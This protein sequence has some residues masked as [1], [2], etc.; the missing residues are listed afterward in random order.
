MGLNYKKRDH[1]SQDAMWTSYS[2]LFLGLSIIFLLLYVAASLRQG[3]DGIRQFIENKQLVQKNADLQQ[4]IKVYNTLKQDYLKTQASEEEQASYN[5]LME[6]LDLLKE[7][8][9]D[10]KN[11]LRQKAMDNEKKEVALN[12]YQQMIRNIINSNMIAKSRIKNRDTLIDERDEEI[13]V[14]ESEIQDL[15]KNVAE[16]RAQI[17]LG[18]KKIDT[19]E[20]Q[21]D[22]KLKQLQSSY[23]AQKL[24]KK[25]YEQQQAALRGEFEQKIDSLKQQN[26]SASQE[27]SK[28]AQKLQ[29]TSS[30]LQSTQGQLS[31]AA[32]EK[33]RLAQDKERLAQDLES[34]KA[35]SER[36]AKDL[37]GQL[38]T[39]GKKFQATQADLAK[40]TDRL[41]AQRNLAD[42]IKKSFG[43][44]GVEADVDAETGDVI[45]SFGDQY[46]DTGKANLKPQ[47]RKILEQAMPVYSQSLFADAKIADKIQSVE[48]VGFAS[49]TFKGKFIDPKSLKPEDRQ[50]IN[51]NLD[52]SYNRARSIFNHVFDKDKM[53]FDHQE[54][55]IPLVKVTGRSFLAH[56]KDKNYKSSSKGEDFCR[57]NDCAKLQRVIIK[58]TLKD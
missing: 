11:M 27:L 42:K 24:T 51:Y 31:K 17:Q 20:D 5:V 52:L 44:A 16:K 29:Q 37:K 45:L 1:G 35:Q 36:T 22:Q 38:G 41:N 48:I 9:K 28:V 49:P 43:K 26:Q 53:T 4:Q 32:Q 39:L 46:F 18:E 15:E 54:R 13:T 19:L 6:K 25:K 47:M 3:T 56:E 55:L 57:V 40:A 34:T 7:E 58:F 14:K 8:A 21:L 23:Q 33:E 2:D 30:A 50:A 10:E 12:Q